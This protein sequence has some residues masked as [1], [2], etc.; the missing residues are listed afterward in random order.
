MT[1]IRRRTYWASALAGCVLTA[2]LGGPAPHTVHPAEWHLFYFG[3]GLFPVLM[4]CLVLGCNWLAARF[5]KGLRRPRLGALVVTGLFLL[6][7]VYGLLT[8]PA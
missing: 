4:G 6:P 2:A 7:I 8:R 3:Q 5:G 1:D